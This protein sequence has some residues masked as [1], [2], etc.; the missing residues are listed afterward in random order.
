MSKLTPTAHALLA[1]LNIKPW[2]AY[3][4][5]RFMRR[6]NL[7]AIWP[8]AESR[9]YAE[10]KNLLQEALIRGKL[11]H[12]GGRKRT[13]YEITAKGRRVLQAWLCQPVEKRFVYESEAMLKVAFGDMESLE[14]LKQNVAGIRAEA[15]DDLAIMQ[16]VFE[17]IVKTGLPFPERAH[18]NA[19]TAQFTL[20]MVEARLRWA[21]FA[22]AF[23]AEWEDSGGDEA[24]E[25]QGLSWYRDAIKRI[26]EL[27]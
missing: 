6:S 25:A 13:I 10:P 15:E 19:L 17:E 22:E 24:K 11:E 21:R 18:V 5:T 27:R 2:S 4:L 9:L 3:E 16:E 20:D 1:L 26:K 7:R 23:I 8:R 12:N 14:T